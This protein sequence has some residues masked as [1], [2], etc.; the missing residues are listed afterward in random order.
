MIR[1]EVVACLGPRGWLRT[2]VS[3]PEGACVRDALSATGW[4]EASNLEADAAVGV[5]GR[6]RSPGEAVREGDRVELYRPLQCD[7]KE[8]RRLRYRQSPRRRKAPPANGT[9]LS[10]NPPQ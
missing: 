10:G 1:V 4:A 5:W 2:E 7:P 6:R 8:A 3:L 9:D